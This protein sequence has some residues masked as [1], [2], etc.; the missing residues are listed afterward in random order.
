MRQLLFCAIL[1]LLP[2][3]L[4]A[5]T[6]TLTQLEDTLR[7]ARKM[8]NKLLEV[9]TDI[10]I[11]DY[12]FNQKDYD[13]ADRYY[14]RSL[15]KN[16]NNQFKKQ[17][18]IANWKRGVVQL[19]KD[20]LEEA[21]KTLHEALQMAVQYELTE[22]ED[23]IKHDIIELENISLDKSNASRQY[24]TLKSMNEDEAIDFML[25]QSKQ[26]DEENE[27]F[28]SKISHL[29]K[30]KQLAQLKLR[31]KEKVVRENELQ[32]ELLNRYSREKEFEV[33]QKEKELKAKNAALKQQETQNE[34][35][36]IIIWFSVVGL[37]LLSMFV[38]Y[39]IRSN[40]QKRN[41]NEALIEKN[42]II[43]LKNKEIIDS[44][45]YA[46]RIQEATLRLSKNDVSSFS[47]SFFLLKPK[48]IVSGD[49]YWIRA[50]GEKII[51]AVAD[52]TGHGVPGAF[53]SMIGNR[54]LNEI[55][56]EK[57][58]YSANEILDEL[59]SKIIQSLNQGGRTEDSKDGMDIAL[60]VLD[61]KTMMVDFAGAN[62]PIYVM[63]KNI[64]QDKNIS[65]DG[66]KNYESNLIEIKANRFPVGYHPYINA[67]FVNFQFKAQKGD[68]IYMFSDGFSDQ[69]GGNQ[70]KKFTSKRFKKLLSSVYELPMEQQKE[71]LITT[72]ESWKDDLEQIDDVCVVGVKL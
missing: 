72:L 38:F 51:W 11:G 43:V 6:N 54:L 25:K 10:A 67:S 16:N 19:K 26:S 12:Y 5:Q 52:C 22:I 37:I 61:K 14:R 34:K 66:T 64:V 29:S 69:F 46:K 50:V 36:Q 7:E 53:M 20:G 33:L 42:K 68:V 28:L 30:A 4:S 1:F 2:N 44:I 9:Q 13:K 32:I 49:F 58:I 70:A 23:K 27:Q 35:Q 3:L 47:D 39:A 41:S 71:E 56:I 62:N 40:V 65:L 48:D 15:R 31:L 60:C 17:L 8:D 55:I 59:K 21:K 57:N 24:D 63:R 18:V 45:N